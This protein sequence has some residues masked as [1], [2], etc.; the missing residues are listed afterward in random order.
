MTQNRLDRVQAR[1]DAHVAAGA[2]SGIEWAV[3][4]RGETFCQGRAGLADALN[5]REMAKVPIYRI[6]S[7]TK[8][9]VSAVA[10]MLVE[11]GKIRLMDPVAAYLP[12]FGKM[13]VL[14]EGGARAPRS[15]MTIEHLLTHRAGLSYSF[16]HASCPVAKTMLGSDFLHAKYSLEDI[17]NRIPEFGLSFDPG[18]AWRYSVGTDVV[19]RIIELVEQKPLQ[20]VLKE[21][22]FEPLGVSD[23]GFSV[24]EV[25]QHRV[26]GMFGMENLDH[27]FDVEPGGQ[28]LTA[29]ANIEAGYP[30]NNPGYARG[31]L[32][33]YSTL[34]DYLKIARFLGDGKANGV[35]VLGRK[36]LEWMWSDRV[37]E[38]QKPLMLGPV[39]LSG[40]GYGLAG[41]VMSEPRLAMG[42]T[43]LGE[44]GWAGA[45]STYFWIDPAEDLVG[46]VMSQYL[47]SKIPLG[48]DIRV[49]VYQALE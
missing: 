23:T 29:V 21:R 49:A 11:E 19:G 30:L 1:A 16:L 37:P 31:G 6:Y 38:A 15:M 43:S 9:I 3:E 5:G 34:P 35:T 12:A 44:I 39:A 17:C 41:R 26:M 45:A 28:K 47:G 4:R 42:F 33:L 25:A 24:P 36:A 46:V 13:Q 2:F 18:T 32:G 40:Y 20:D 14:E 10:M 27:L 7:M 48:D 8:P 22:V